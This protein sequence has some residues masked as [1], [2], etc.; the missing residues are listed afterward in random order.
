M[1]RQSFR[2]SVVVFT[3][4]L[5]LY[6]CGQT[7]SLPSILPRKDQDKK[8]TF[9]I[10]AALKGTKLRKNLRIDKNELSL[11]GSNANKFNDLL[12]AFL[13]PTKAPTKI[14]TKSPFKFPT[15]IPTNFPSKSP[16]KSPSKTPT[17][18][19]SK[20][21]VIGNSLRKYATV[22]NGRLNYK[23]NVL[24]MVEFF[25][26]NVKLSEC[27]KAIVQESQGL[28]YA[29]YGVQAAYNIYF[30]NAVNDIDASF[31]DGTGIP[32][33]IQYDTFPVQSILGFHSTN[34]KGNFNGTSVSPQ[35]NFPQEY[36]FAF[37]SY[38]SVLNYLSPDYSYS[39][40]D[41]DDL[42]CYAISQQIFNTLGDS[43][44]RE[45]SYFATNAQAFQN[46]QVAFVD[47]NFKLVPGGYTVDPD[48]NNYYL[49]TVPDIFSNTAG[50]LQMQVCDP[51]SYSVLGKY[52]SFLVNGYY[53]SNYVTKEWFDCYYSSDQLQYDRMRRVSKP[54][55]PFGGVVSYYL[56]NFE[57]TY[58]SVLN[59]GPAWNDLKLVQDI[60]IPSNTTLLLYKV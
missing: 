20:S 25:Y 47:S 34:Q 10:N 33:I 26:S 16:T 53:I 43:T 39:F 40:S 3:F 7:K 51:V 48:T 59:F 4:I 14:P 38:S 1:L 58:F 11:H 41:S 30:S 55:I 31:W 2:P 54:C 45:F 29:S 27:M 6:Y 13:L 35:S 44:A 23:F 42:M 8:N 22:V 46:V 36:P 56:P 9:N 60:D 28:F 15:K 21:P 32:L 24:N 19:P 5:C 57:N 49:P 17:Y 12:F 52:D 37:V 50:F 18:L